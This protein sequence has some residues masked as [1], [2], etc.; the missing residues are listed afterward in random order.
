MPSKGPK[1]GLNA[2]MQTMMGSICFRREKIGAAKSDANH[3]KDSFLAQT[4]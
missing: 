1:G 3:E 4:A 2:L